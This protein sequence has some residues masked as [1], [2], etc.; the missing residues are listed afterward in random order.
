MSNF[1][2]INYSNFVVVGVNNLEY[3]EALLIGN[4]YCVHI[5]SS[6]LIAMLAHG[7]SEICQREIWVSAYSTIY[8][9][10][11][12]YNDCALVVFS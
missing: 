9:P 1:V 11:I 5:W 6:F 3:L 4:V 10:L 2:G 12:A 8:N 7:N